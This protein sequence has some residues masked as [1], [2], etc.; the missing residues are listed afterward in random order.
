MVGGGNVALRK[1]SLLSRTKASIIVISP[2]VNEEI[3]EGKTDNG[4]NIRILNNEIQYSHLQ[5][6]IPQLQSEPFHWSIVFSA[7]SSNEINQQISIWCHELNIL[8]N[9]VDN[10]TLCSFISPAIVDRTPIVI[11]ISTEGSS[12]VRLLIF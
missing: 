8:V 10:P 1:I 3:K 9:V 5:G 6:Y 4:G 7:T 11:A 12:P 2:S